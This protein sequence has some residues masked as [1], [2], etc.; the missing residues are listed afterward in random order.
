MKGTQISNIRRHR[1]HSG[2]RTDVT[3]HGWQQ[4]W[5]KWHHEQCNLNIFA[6]NQKLNKYAKDGQ[7]KKAMHLFQ[8]MQQEGSSTNEF[9]FV[10]VIDAYTG[11]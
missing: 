4:R 3:C 6:W 10:L 5:L 1:K 7:P 8:Q 9:T 11:L 2:L